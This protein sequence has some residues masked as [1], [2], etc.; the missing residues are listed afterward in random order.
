[1]RG[2]GKSSTVGDRT[3]TEVTDRSMGTDLPFRNRGF[4]APVTGRPKPPRVTPTVE[5][6]GQA[7]DAEVAVGALATPSSYHSTAPA[8]NHVVTSTKG[9]KL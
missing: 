2:D 9:G 7:P 4:G 5:R 1:M 3:D 6:N 8:P